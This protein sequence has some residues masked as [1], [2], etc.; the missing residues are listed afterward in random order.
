[1]QSESDKL[2]LFP[3]VSSS[4]LSCRRQQWS[5]GANTKIMLHQISWFTYGVSIISSVIIY[6]LYVALTYYRTEFKMTLYKLTGKQP[7][8]KAS[9]SG[10]FQLPDYEIMGKAQTDDVEFINQTELFFAP[11]NIPDEESQ[12]E[13]HQITVPEKDSK[14]IGDFSEMVSEVKTLIRVINESSE[15]KENFEMLLRLILQK[16]PALKGTIYQDQIIEFLIA[17]GIPQFPFS[18]SEDELNNYWLNER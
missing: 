5:C 2:G 12:D 10:D 11:A 14:L 9:G 18:L 4:N 1:L 13:L 6:Y 7:V 17:E 3:Q 16:Y 15:S 8:V